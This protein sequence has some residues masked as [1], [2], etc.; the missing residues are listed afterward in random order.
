MSRPAAVRPEMAGSHMAAV[1]ESIE[2]Y[3]TEL[4]DKS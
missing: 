2:R 4:Q 3:Q 1:A